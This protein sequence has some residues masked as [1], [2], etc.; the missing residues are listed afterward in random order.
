[1]FSGNKIHVSVLEPANDVSVTSPSMSVNVSEDLT[2]TG[3]DLQSTDISSF[4]ATQV[5][6][7]RPQAGD[8][9]HHA[10][11]QQ[12]PFTIGM[13]I[14]GKCETISEDHIDTD[15]DHQSTVSLSMTAAHNPIVS[16]LLCGVEQHVCELD[17]SDVSVASPSMSVSV[18]EDFIYTDT[19]DQS[20]VV[21]SLPI[22]PAHNRSSKKRKRY[23]KGLARGWGNSK[24][25]TSS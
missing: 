3:T 20:P 16:K 6:T 17:S 1:M 11:I 22:Q 21:H 24:K 4:S 25:D 10:C 23:S 7:D 15:T 8:G 19:N 12:L 13:S 18:P 9:K 14:S 2:Y 5:T